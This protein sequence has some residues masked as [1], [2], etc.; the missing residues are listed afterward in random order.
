M[1]PGELDDEE[2]GMSYAEMLKRDQRRWEVADEDND[3]ALSLDEFTNFLHPEESERMRAVVVQE[4]MEDIDKD[5]DGKI[6]L[7]EYIGDMYHGDDDE[8]E[9]SWVSNERDQ[10]REFRDKDND[11]YLDEEEVQGWIIPPDYNHADAEAKHLIYEADDNA[12]KMLTKEEILN[13]YDVFV[14]SQA[15]DFG[16]ALVRHDEF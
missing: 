10:F 11:G 7:E 9:P 5:K 6:S 16:E 13:K 2:E 12:D 8:F 14:G 3:N 1:D 4:T 15:T